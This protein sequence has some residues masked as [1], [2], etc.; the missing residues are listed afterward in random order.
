MTVEHCVVNGSRAALTPD[1][2]RELVR[3][4]FHRHL[5][6]GDVSVLFDCGQLKDAVGA[7]RLNHRSLRGDTLEVTL[8]GL[9]VIRADNL[10][11]GETLSRSGRG[12]DARRP[13]RAAEVPWVVAALDLHLHRP[14]REEARP[15]RRTEEGTRRGVRQREE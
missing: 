4:G 14:A 13:E 7:R 9:V 1:H 10:S 11:G 2:A 8:P 3:G 5:E 12:R 15:R 6:V